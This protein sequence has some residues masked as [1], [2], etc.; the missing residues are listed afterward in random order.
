MKEDTK[1]AQQ[2]KAYFLFLEWIAD[3]MNNSGI[4]M[5]ELIQDISL[6]PTKTVLHEVFKSIL[7]SMYHKDSTKWITRQE[8]NDCLDILMD[9]LAI[10]WVNLDFPDSSKQNLLQFY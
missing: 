7:L 5:N 9:A 1:T 4:S 10:K 8:M 6:K 2:T 3:E